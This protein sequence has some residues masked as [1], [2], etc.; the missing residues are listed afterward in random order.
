MMATYPNCLRLPGPNPH[1]HSLF[2]WE[3][4]LRGPLY[5]YQATPITWLKCAIAHLLNP[6]N[7]VIY[8]SQLLLP[9]RRT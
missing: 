2:L 6:R 9:L 5:R 7:G 1:D 3:A 8:P 4:H